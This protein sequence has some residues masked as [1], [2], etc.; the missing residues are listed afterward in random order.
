[1]NKMA[2]YIQH[3][4]PDSRNLPATC[5]DIRDDDPFVYL[6]DEDCLIW[7]SPDG[8]CYMN[9]DGEVGLVP[10]IETPIVERKGKFRGLAIEETYQ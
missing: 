6:D 3:K 9:P 5:G 7:M 1:M 8:P 10:D 4:K 2:C